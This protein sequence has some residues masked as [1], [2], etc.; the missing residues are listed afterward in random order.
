M[1]QG[2]PVDRIFALER[3]VAR[4]SAQAQAQALALAKLAGMKEALEGLKVGG[5]FGAPGSRKKNGPLAKMWGGNAYVSIDEIPGRA[6]PYDLTVDIDIGAGVVDAQQESAYISQDGPFI[7]VRR[8]MA[9]RSDYTFSVQDQDDQTAT[10]V[11][12]TSGRFRPISSHTDIMD[13]VHAFEQVSQYQP[14]YLGAVA[15]AGGGGPAAGLIIPV[16]NP[17]G[18]HAG[19]GDYA[20]S[21]SLLNQ[22]PNFPGNG[23]PIMVSPLSMSSGRS[24]AFDGLVAVELAGANY[25]RQNAPV[26]SAFWMKGLGGP[27][28]LACC[29]VFEPGDS[30]TIKVTPTHPNNPAFGDIQSLMYMGTDVTFDTAKGGGANDPAPAGPFPFVAGQF[31]GH[32]GVNAQSYAGDSTTT[33][34]RA[35]RSPDG[36][37]TIG[38]QGYKLVQPPRGV[39]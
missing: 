28:D 39:G 30:V 8:Y 19:D 27:L 15:A 7:A 16:A 21:L 31:D 24:M 17:M 2:N 34:D 26:P 11:G 36:I 20:A 37:V 29:D 13:A 22:L 10:F 1:T 6:I 33:A 23:R 25:Q 18:V 4:Q 9:F 14:S 38:Y 35:T 12:R 5:D 3:A 32:E